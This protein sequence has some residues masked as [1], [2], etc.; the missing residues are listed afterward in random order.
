MAIMAY[1]FEMLLADPARGPLSFTGS[2]SFIK[3]D[4]FFV[5][6]DGFCI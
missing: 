2:D 1:V 3:I 5:Q 6:N 4:E